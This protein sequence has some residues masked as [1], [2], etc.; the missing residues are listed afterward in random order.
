FIRQPHPL[1]PSPSAPSGGRDRCV[2]CFLDNPEWPLESG[3]LPGYCLCSNR[4]HRR[5]DWPGNI[6]RVIAGTGVAPDHTPAIRRSILG[7]TR[8]RF[9]SPGRIARSSFGPIRTPFSFGVDL[10]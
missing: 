6:E 8:A 4:H 5:A 10:E 1:A 7:S 3:T 9:G 2:L